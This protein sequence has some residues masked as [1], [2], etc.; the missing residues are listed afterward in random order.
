[1][2]EYLKICGDYDTDKEQF[3]VFRHGVQIVPGQVRR[4]LKEAI[5]WLGLD[6][7]VYGMHSLHGGRASDLIKAGFTV[8]QA[9]RMER[10][11]SNAVFC[12]IK[13]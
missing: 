5:R 6:H 10:W 9:Q 8:K 3:F 4:V 12:Y 11:H 2:R 7:A 13:S 1:M